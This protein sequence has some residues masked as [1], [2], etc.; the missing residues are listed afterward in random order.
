MTSKPDT[1]ENLPAP[2]VL[3]GIADQFVAARR[4]AS[5]LA[6]YPGPVPDSLQTAYRIQD[7][8]I[9]QWPDAVGGWKVGRIPP[10]V[11]DQFGCDRLA[12]PI[13]KKTIHEQ[14]SGITH[15]MP[16]IRGGFGAIEAEYVAVIAKDAPADK[17][18]WSLDEAKSMI[19]DLR[20]GLEVAASP[21]KTINELGPAVVASDFGNNAGLIVGPSI[22]DWQTRDLESLACESFIDGK[23][24]G[25]GG[26]F[27][28]TGGYL[29]S[30]Q[31]IL[32]LAA[33]RGRALKAGHVI[34]TGQT[35]GIHDVLPMQATWIEFAGDGV[36]KC[37]IV[38]ATSLD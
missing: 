30:V 26:A 37:Q 29:R 12:G 18:E 7:L 5:P 16:V 22:R 6:D 23:S 14:H 32:E 1:A 8:A 24:V 36:I 11:E 20:I 38:A 10:A 2:H 34:A 33:K 35:N 3:Q 13:F 4:T 21:L 31:F 28:L 19:G 27:M 17:L 25:S 15:S 9:E